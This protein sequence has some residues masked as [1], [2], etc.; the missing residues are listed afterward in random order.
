MYFSK[1]FQLKGLEPKNKGCTTFYE[2]C[3]LT[4]KVYLIYIEEQLQQ[5]KRVPWFFG[6]ATVDQVKVRPKDCLTLC[7][8]IV[9]II[10][11]HFTFT[12]KQLVNYINTLCRFPMFSQ[13]DLKLCF[14]IESAILSQLFFENDF[15]GGHEF[16][17]N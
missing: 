2:C 16:Y 1:I 17:F 9:Y 8:S 4:K 12:K 7:F 11:Q 6:W 13:C 5:G 14:S 3:D 15:L 10:Q